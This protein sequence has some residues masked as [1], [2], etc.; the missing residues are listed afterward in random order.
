M[1]SLSFLGEELRADN[2]C[3]GGLRGCLFY[4]FKVWMSDKMHLFSQIFR[5]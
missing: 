2:D 4:T 5:A 1:V 3:L